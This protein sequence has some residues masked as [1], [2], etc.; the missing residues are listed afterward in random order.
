MPTLREVY[1]EAVARHGKNSRVAKV[2]KEQ[3]EAFEKPS[4]AAFT[5]LGRPFDNGAPEDEKLPL[6]SLNAAFCSPQAH[7][8]MRLREL[9]VPPNHVASTT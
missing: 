4:S 1:E 6:K 8:M 3:M 9:E 7:T 2:L 5:Y